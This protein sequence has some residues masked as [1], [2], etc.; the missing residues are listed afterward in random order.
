M[1]DARRHLPL[2]PWGE[3]FK[4]SAP[5]ASQTGRRPG[6]VTE[7]RRDFRALTQASSEWNFCLS[8][9]PVGYLGPFGPF[10]PKSKLK[11]HKY[12]PEKSILIAI[13]GVAK[14]KSALT[15]VPAAYPLVE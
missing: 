13:G 2:Q 11:Q 9:T 8:D 4:G 6:N 7:L 14:T 3:P 12:S 15:A 1:R 10:V 5:G